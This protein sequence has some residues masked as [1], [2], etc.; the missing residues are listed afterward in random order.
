MRQ[1]SQPPRTWRVVLIR[2]SLALVV[3]LVVVWATQLRPR[4]GAASLERG[5]AGKL[6]GTPVRCSDQTRNGSKWTCLVGA[7]PASL[8]VV[9]SVSL[10][11][12][13]TVK[14]R[15]PHCRYP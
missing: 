6:H 7:P 12:S 13:W 3:L 1:Q 8:C 11:G 9:V 15:P 14:E 10:T 4:I 2:G 5:V